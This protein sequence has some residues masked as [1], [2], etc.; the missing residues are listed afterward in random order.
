M[1]V[2]EAEY[3]PEL[4]SIELISELR[5]LLSTERHAERLICRYLADLADRIR[6]RSDMLLDAYVD[7]FHATRCFFQL[8]VRDTR[9]RVRIGRALRLLPR[10]H[11]LIP[12]ASGGAHS[13]AN[14]IVLCTT[15]HR[16]L[17]EGK[18]R[19]IG[20]TER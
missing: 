13:R 11:H 10:V 14:C 20:D 17:H 3:R 1:Q 6:A 8:G 2:R 7:E 19:I 16:L 12:Q 9:E 5:D 18:L 4:S 15:H